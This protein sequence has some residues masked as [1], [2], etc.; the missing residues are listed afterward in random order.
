MIMRASPR[1]FR[2]S[3]LPQRQRGITLIIGMI[4][5]MMLTVVATI[6]FRNTTLSEKMSSG[7]RDRNVAF[8]SAESAAQEAVNKIVTSGVSSTTGYYITPLPLGA[9]ASYWTFGS[10][11]TLANPTTE[12]ANLTTQFSWTSCAMSAD[13]RYGGSANAARYVIELLASVTATQSIE[14]FSTITM[15][16]ATTVVTKQYDTYRV[17]TRSTG[18]SDNSDVVLQTIFNRETQLP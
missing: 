4:L 8:Q 7:V 10:G 9:D 16:T 18:A 6:G 3:R 12:C 2:P 1:Y 15:A 5:L 11:P 14:K 13:E 17:T